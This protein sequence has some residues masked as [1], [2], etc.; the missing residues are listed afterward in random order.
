MIR[1]HNS[2]SS[3][4]STEK[5]M[6]ERT[7]LLGGEG[8]GGTPTKV[9]YSHISIDDTNDEPYKTDA[10]SSSRYLTT[11]RPSLL[12]ASFTL[13]LV[14]M[15]FY[16]SPPVH[17]Q[18]HHHDHTIPTFLSIRNTNGMYVNALDNA[19]YDEMKFATFHMNTH[20]SLNE[21]LIEVDTDMI[22]FHQNLTLSW[23]EEEH[24]AHADSSENNVIAL[25]CPAGQDAKKFTEAA[26][27][28][29]IQ[30][31]SIAEGLHHTKRNEWFIP[32]FPVIKE[33]SCEFRLWIRQ[34]EE[35]TVFTLGA[36]SGLLMIENGSIVPTAIHLAL[37]SN[38]DEMLVHFSTGSNGYHLNLVPVVLYGK[39]EE[40]LRHDNNY[41]TS[42]VLHINVGD[43]TTYTASDMCQAPA[44]TQEPGKFIAPG[45]LHSVT[46]KNLDPDARY[47]YKVALMD[48]DDIKLTKGVVWSDIYSF[49]SPLPAGTIPANGG[50]PLKYVVYADQGLPGY[51]GGDDGDRVSL[52]A[53]R[54]I[55]LHGIRAVHHFGDLSYAQV[56]C[57]VSVGWDAVGG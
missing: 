11:T 29:Q 12:I 13:L 35:G 10:F 1:R 50:Q 6:N 49:Q 28:A 4:S 33:D 26:T 39:G 23:K 14:T 31:T 20:A 45:L 37:T 53:E 7:G 22:S 24:H 42:N 21:L 30:A 27:I 41:T 52:F 5:Q 32:S 25:Y 38:N 9:Y 16:T 54:E 19:L 55:E 17:P 34:E 56:S 36:T 2:T 46:M 51:G 48:R 44:N 3:M 57:H 40:G 47:F 8:G 43:S 18:Q 15:K